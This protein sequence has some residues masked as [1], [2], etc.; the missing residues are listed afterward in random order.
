MMQGVKGT[1]SPLSQSVPDHVHRDAAADVLCG[2]NAID[3]LLHLA[4]AAVAAF[5]GIGGCGQERFVEKRQRL[6][7]GWGKEFIER[8]A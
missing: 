5:N 6:F 1:E 2:S 7:N 4:V 8:L 3:G